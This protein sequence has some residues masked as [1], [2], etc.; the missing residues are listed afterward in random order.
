MNK[1]KNILTK[2][3]FIKGNFFSDIFVVIKQNGGKKYSQ[4]NSAHSS[5]TTNKDQ[6][7][8]LAEI[9]SFFGAT[10]TSM[11]KKLDSVDLQIKNQREEFIDLVRKV[12]ITDNKDVRIKIYVNTVKIENNDFQIEQLKRE[13]SALSEEIKVIKLDMNNVKN[14]ILKNP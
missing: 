3:I 10:S 8:G 11:E 5:T 2:S 12:E 7:S 6:D 4:A 9:K 1:P 13:I 14:K